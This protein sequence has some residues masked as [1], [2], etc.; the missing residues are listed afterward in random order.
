MTL[1][2]NFLIVFALLLVLEACK[3][4]D[5]GPTIVPPRDVGEVALENDAQIIEFL[6]THFYY[7]DEDEDSGADD[8]DRNEIIIDTISGDNADETPLMDFVKIRKVTISDV[9]HNLYYIVVREGA[10]ESPS[11][12]AEALMRYKGLTLDGERF[13]VNNVG[14]ILNLPRTVT[15]FNQFAPFLKTGSGFTPNDDGTINWEDDYGMGI[16]IMPS[17]LAY[18]NSPPG[19]IIGQYKPILFTVEMLQFK[20]VD[21]DFY[22][23]GNNEIASPD[24]I[25]SK[26]EDLNGDGNPYNDDTDGDG[27][28]NMFDPDDDN[29]GILTLY[30]YDQNEDGIPDDTDGDGIPDYLDNK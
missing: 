9:E 30:E 27:Q 29:D 28:P 6:E 13:D 11:F 2:K 23:S 26:D 14:G 15:G 8:N 10:G 5:D 3:K 4:D 19:S 1:K 18:F 25:L 7:L 20:E 24:G 22:L 12:G 21:N 16:V 17:G